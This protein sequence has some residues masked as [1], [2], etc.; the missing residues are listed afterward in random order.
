MHNLP[1]RLS[2]KKDRLYPIFLKLNGRR[3]LVVGAGKTAEEKIDVLLAS[4]A[5]VLVV[6]PVATSQ[7]QS[8]AHDEDIFWMRKRFE[9]QDLEGIFLAV[10]ATSSTP[11]N[12]TVFQ[13]AHSRDVL[14]NVIHDRAH[15]DFYYPAV[16]RRGPLQIAIST[17]GNS[18]ALAQRLR[19][20]LELQFGPE[21][22]IWLKW[23]D[24]ARKSLYDDPLT[25]KRRRTMLHKL[26][27]KKKQEEFFRR[28]ALNKMKSG[29]CSR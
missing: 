10:V 22:E 23:L 9:P 6:A 15:C 4:G 14:C 12:R 7:I 19:Q 26:S 28:L 1:P 2:A 25:P 20:E 29:E 17:A 13:E 21:W 24:E 8:W 18:G 3:C 11:V 5:T 27:A 16:V